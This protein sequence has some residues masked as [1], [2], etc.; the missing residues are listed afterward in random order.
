MI[1]KDIIYE[2]KQKISML[3]INDLTSNIY[4][5][6]AH[7]EILSLSES[8]LK[9]AQMVGAVQKTKL[10]SYGFKEFYMIGSDYYEI[11]ADYDLSTHR[12]QILQPLKRIN[13][14]EGF[15]PA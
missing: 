10:F 9:N 1:S 11:E 2:E 5:S 8:A 4:F 3:E 15:I 14:Y 13:L 7:K 6:A 12:I